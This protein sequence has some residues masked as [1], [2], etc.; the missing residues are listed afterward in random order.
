M[1]PTTG[2]NILPNGKSLSPAGNK[3][4]NHPLSLSLH[5]LRYTS[6]HWKEI[7]TVSKS[8]VARMQG[9]INYCCGY[10][11]SKAKTLGLEQV[12]SECV[13]CVATKVTVFVVPVCNRLRES[14]Y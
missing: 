3:R 12:P 7:K 4:T 2:L 14:S 11:A 5:P 8:F 1:G 10:T 13:P 6:S 9:K